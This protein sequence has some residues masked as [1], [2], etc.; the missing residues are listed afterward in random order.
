V[1]SEMC[2]RDSGY[3]DRITVQFSEN[4]DISD[5]GGGGD[6][7]DCILV[8]GYTITN[9][10]YGA[11]DVSTVALL[12]N[13]GVSYD[14]GATP[15]TAY[16]ISGSSTI[17]DRAAAPNEM[18]N[19][20][21]ETTADGAKPIMI[22]A[23][24]NDPDSNDIDVGDYI[25]VEFTEPVQLAC[26]SSSDFELL[27]AAFGDSFGAPG[28]SLDDPTP[29]DVYINIVLG[30]D[31]Y[32][33]L[34]DLWSVPGPGNPSGIGIKAGG[35]T[36]VEDL[37][38]QKSPQGAEVDIGGAGSNLIV[39]V[40][41]TDG[42]SVFENPILPAAF[43]DSDITI[44]IETQFNANFVTVW[45]DVGALPDGL[46]SANPN[47]RRVVATGSAKSWTATI[48]HDD[49]EMVEGAVV[50]FLVD[51]DGAIY[52]SDGPESLGGSV[53]WDFKVFYEQSQRVT[54]RNNVINP[55]NGDVTY[56]NYYIDSGR[57]VTITAYDLAGNPVKVLFDG[58]GSAG[59]NLVTW[60]GRN[61]N[62]AV[63]VPGV[64]YM[65]IKIGSDR[66]VRKVLIV[67]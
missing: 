53:P 1:G 9:G 16:S 45:F 58:T 41:A 62:G 65:V 27:N 33:I 44:S 17:L 55:H 14:T 40:T 59:T 6:G 52:Y 4:V 31:P 67:K 15:S 42:S 36:C 19:G 3:I 38:S 22:S 34:P 11:A 57:K 24:F 39:K 28:S 54:I 12:I 48:P 5:A 43:M 20:E 32:L 10:S 8:A 13:E 2:I 66:Y 60:N 51:T 63:V 21:T 61:R 64:Y 50:R 49:A 29:G 25:Q 37:L 47:D 30:T 18:L 23:V 26:T 35:T 46:S 56:I 7:L